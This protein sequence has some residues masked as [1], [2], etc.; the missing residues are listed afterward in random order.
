AIL[1]RNY[2]AGFSLLLELGEASLA[3]IQLALGLFDIGLLSLKIGGVPILDALELVLRLLDI[4]SVLLLIA[5]IL[6]FLIHLDVEDG[7]LELRLRFDHRDAVGFEL[8]A[9]DEILLEQASGGFEF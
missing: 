6:V 2:R 4:R 7:L 3:D 8:V 5:H 1:R 9:A